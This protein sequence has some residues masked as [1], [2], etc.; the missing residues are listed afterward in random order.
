M[1]AA[2]S[3]GGT[4]RSH[5]TQ[6]IGDGKAIHIYLRLFTEH[7]AQRV[8][9]KINF[10]IKENGIELF[11]FICKLKKFYLQAKKVSIDFFRKIYCDTCDTCDTC[12]IPR[13]LKF[14]SHFA[15]YLRIRM[16]RNTLNKQLKNNWELVQI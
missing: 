9:E 14:S 12:G 8:V 15:I 13:Y 11:Y 5:F 6:G 7:E 3:P 10:R 16:K 1:V 2:F 4:D